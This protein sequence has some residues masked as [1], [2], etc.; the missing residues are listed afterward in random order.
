MW[1]G[2]MPEQKREIIEGIT[3]VFTDQGVP[4]QAVT[5]IIQEIPKEQWGSAGVPASEK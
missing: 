2:R 4:P 3:K 1:P 5:I